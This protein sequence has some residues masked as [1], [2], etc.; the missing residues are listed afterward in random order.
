MI[1][2]Q[3][4]LEARDHG[5]ICVVCRSDWGKTRISTRCQSTELLHLAGDRVFVWELTCKCSFRWLTVPSATDSTAV[6]RRHVQN[7]DLPK[8]VFVFQTCVL[9]SWTQDEYKDVACPY[10]EFTFATFW[11]LGEA[12]FAAS[13]SSSRLLCQLLLTQRRRLCAS[14]IVSTSN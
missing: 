10:D 1:S 5:F 13:P 12:S 7:V 9:P 14:S 11:L 2:E 8:R 3:R 6:R 4:N